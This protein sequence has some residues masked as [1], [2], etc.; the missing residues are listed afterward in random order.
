MAVF[1]RGAFIASAALAMLLVVGAGIYVTYTQSAARRKLWHDFMSRAAL[2]SNLTSVGLQATVRT[3]EAYIRS[4]FGGPADT[5]QYMV[6]R[7][8]PNGSWGVVLD[9]NGRI[10]GANP[11]FLVSQQAAIDNRPEIMAAIAGNVGCS[12]VVSLNG[13]QAVITAISAQ[14]DHGVRIWATALPLRP[15][16]QFGQAYLF[17]ALTNY[18]G[19]AFLVDQN[20]TILA[21]TTD[22]VPGTRTDDLAVTTSVPDGGSRTVGGVTYTTQSISGTPWRIAFAVPTSTLF[23]T[24]NSAR[25]ATWQL[26]AGFALVSICMVLLAARA[27][28]NSERLA[29]ERLHDGL[30]GLPNRTM[31]VKQAEQALAAVRGRGGNLAAMF[32]DLDRFKPINDEYGHKIGDQV[33]RAVAE[34]LNESIRS[35]DVVSRFGGDEFIVLCSRLSGHEQG[36]EIAER[37]QQAVASPCTIDGV[38][39]SVGCSIGIAFYSGPGPELDADTLIQYAD[40]AM[41]EAKKRG[42]ARIE[43]VDPLQPAPA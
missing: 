38:E 12:N 25:L 4:T 36:F 27:I 8:R 22:L 34:R 17:G 13:E 31:F 15:V 32:I 43:S 10:L 33:L 21:S 28:R 40:L 42:R 39:L 19:R 6:D 2:A 1:R 11:R 14:T 7:Q 23:A 26:F 16:T 3:N 20:N 35:G 30:T 18:R 37:I 24:F 41:Y 9:G 5:I 29:H